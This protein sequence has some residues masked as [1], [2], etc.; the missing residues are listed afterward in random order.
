MNACSKG[1]PASSMPETAA[2][3][4]GLFYA[5]RD[6]MR[7]LSHHDELR[8]LIRTLNRAGWPLL[9]TRGFNPIPR[10][11][12]PLPR[13]TGVAA[14]EQLA[15]VELRSADDVHALERSAASAF[16]RQIPLLGVRSPLARRSA[17]A[18]SASFSVAL[19]PY[20]LTAL[21]ER[22]GAMLA[23]PVVEV[24]REV[25]PGKPQRRIDIRPYIVQLAVEN[26]TLHMT[27]EIQNQATARPAEVLSALGLAWQHRNV[28]RMR[29]EWE[30]FYDTARQERAQ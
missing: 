21:Q 20:E 4:V 29:V 1:A 22:I 28:T 12:L 25:A 16:P 9:Y 10:L 5:V 19:L 23:R 18:R 15:V 2:L 6:D 13:S 26:T 8:M 17:P 27:L 30:I 14:D 24:Q 11:S 7:Y 3:V